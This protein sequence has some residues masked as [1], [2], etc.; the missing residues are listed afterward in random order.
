QEQHLALLE[1]IQGVAD[2]HQRRWYASVLLNRLMFIY[3]LQKKG[4]LDHGDLD[5]LQHKLAESQRK[6]KDRYFKSFLTLLFFEGFA[7]PEGQRSP[8]VTSALGSIR[9]LNGGLFLP[10]K[11][12]Q[13]NPRLDVPDRAF[14]NLFALF[15]RYS[16]NLDDTP[17]GKDDEINPDVL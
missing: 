13:E 3:F 12:E 1:L 16:W 14:E 10:H 17:G 15:E 4:F 8:E 2:E 7:K 5:Y 9:Y 6:D 11:V